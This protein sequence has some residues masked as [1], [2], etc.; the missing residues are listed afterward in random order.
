MNRILTKLAND[1]TYDGKLV[2]G[3]DV[4]AN[5]TL[6]LPNLPSV[7]R[8][9]EVER[10]LMKTISNQ[11]DLSVIVVNTGNTSQLN[12]SHRET[13]E[14]MA[15]S[16]DRFTKNVTKCTNISEAALVVYICQALLQAGVKH[17]AIGV[18][19]PFR[20]QV[21]LI[22]SKVRKLDGRHTA[23]GNNQQE[24]VENYPC[25]IEVNTVDQYQGKDK[26]IIIF[27]C[28][29]S[30]DP[31]SASATIDRDTRAD[32]S[33]HDI[34]NDK[35]RL[36]VA[37]TRAQEKFIIIGDR[38]T[39]EQHSTFKQ[40]FNVVNKPCNIQLADKKDGFEWANAFELLATL[41]E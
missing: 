30:I 31:T 7:R 40:L 14:T 9:Y 11:I 29:K 12:A 5:A 37:I 22:R 16:R 6:K 39:L 17:D 41:S 38:A 18:I 33:A 36:T 20:A 10:W 2:C 35:Q 26:K 21:D 32:N 4:V 27:S 15:C 3:N 8:T 25:S 19:A 13:H 24:T 28:T 34:L 1:F 23:H